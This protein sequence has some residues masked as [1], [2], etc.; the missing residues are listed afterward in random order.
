MKAI[1][2]VGGFGTRLKHLL[3]DVPKPMAD[4]SGRP[5]LEY[6]LDYLIAAGVDEV[7]FSVHHMREK[8]SNHFGDKYRNIKISYAVEN[9]PLGTGGAILNSLKINGSDGKFLVLNGDSFQTIDLQKFYQH[10]K[11]KNITV[12]LRKVNDTTRY[13]RVEID[14]S[15]IISFSEKGIPGQGLINAGCYL[16]DGA[17]FRSLELPEKFSIETDFLMKMSGKLPYFVADDYFIDIGI[18]ED[19][20]RAQNEIPAKIKSL[21]S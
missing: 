4:I 13:G 10:N 8:I 2:L 3:P 11:D 6:M 14:S 17:W 18:P 9:E 19:Y 12:V 1:I 5:F 16:I 15:V 7:I 20:M 21:I